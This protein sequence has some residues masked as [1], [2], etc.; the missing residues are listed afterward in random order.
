MSERT[1]A[2][3]QAHRGGEEACQV[4]RIHGP[5]TVRDAFAKIAEFPVA[6]RASAE[7]FPVVIQVDALALVTKKRG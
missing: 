3:N 2:G 7:R 1:D 5:R 6:D 4:R